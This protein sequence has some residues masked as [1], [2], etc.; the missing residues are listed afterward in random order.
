MI[1]NMPC[2]LNDF[3]KKSKGCGICKLVNEEDYNYCA[4]IADKKR[5]I[6]QV[7]VFLNDCPHRKVIPSGTT[8]NLLDGYSSSLINTF[9]KT[10]ML[11]RHFECTCDEIESEN[12]KEKIS[13]V[14]YV[15]ESR[16]DMTKEEIKTEVEEVVEIEKELKE[17]FNIVDILFTEGN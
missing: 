13:C 15:L 7:Y 11:E 17:Y 9:R 12:C 8:I 3:D 5:I 14:K 4:D 6:R 16:S 10:E 1:K 2:T